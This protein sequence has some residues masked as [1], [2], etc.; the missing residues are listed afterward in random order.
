MPA[1]VR[2]VDVPAT[3]SSTYSD[4]TLASSPGPMTPP[5]LIP[6][7]L[8]AKGYRPSPT[9]SATSALPPSQVQMNKYLAC[10]PGVG[11]LLLW[12]LTQDCNTARLRTS[13]SWPTLPFEVLATPATTPK[14]ASI[15]IVCGGFP[16]AITVR[17]RGSDSPW[18]STP[19]VTVGDVLFTLYR[20]LRLPVTDAEISDVRDSALRQR[21]KDA[22]ARRCNSIADPAHR[23]VEISKRIKRVDFLCDKRMF[24][25]LSLV[26]EGLPSMGLQPGVVWRLHV[27]PPGAR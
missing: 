5:A 24:Q 23:D 8:P 15:T 3:P 22:F 2:F 10:L 16:W 12:D 18:G 4:A 27:S 1:R 13:D 17:P 11:S 9:L 20:A 25:G 7:P 14:L 19:Y 21:V 26:P 6:S